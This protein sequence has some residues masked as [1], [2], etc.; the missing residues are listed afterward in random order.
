M[1]RRSNPPI[2]LG[3]ITTRLGPSTSV[4]H[5]LSARVF[6]LADSTT[7]VILE[8]HAFKLPPH[9]LARARPQLERARGMWS[10][11]GAFAR[12]HVYACVRCMWSAER[13]VL[14][15]GERTPIGY[16]VLCAIG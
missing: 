4:L 7:V 3:P 12:M 5:T 8:L 6:L 16:H 10:M 1:L 11:C 2:S 9:I 14:A 15:M 13:R